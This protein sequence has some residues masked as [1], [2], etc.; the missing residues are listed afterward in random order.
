MNEIHLLTDISTYNVRARRNYV[1]YSSAVIQ[2]LYYTKEIILNMD[3][4]ERKEESEGSDFTLRQLYHILDKDKLDVIN[5]LQSLGLLSKRY[6]CPTCNADM[7]LIKRND[8]SDGYLW[9]CGKESGPREQQHRVTRSLRKGTWFS[10]SRLTLEECLQLTYFWIHEWS[11]KMVK[12]ELKV[13]EHTICDWYNICRVV[14][15]I[16]LTG[17]LIL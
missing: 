7:A 6:S 4:Y 17:N 15:D 13:S 8:L 12:H 5:Y 14:C 1:Q 3:S 9:V 2:S 10:G 11:Q 16:I